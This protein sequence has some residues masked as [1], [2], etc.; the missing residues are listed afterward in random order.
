MLVRVDSFVRLS[1]FL[2]SICLASTGWSSGSTHTTNSNDS[3][4]PNILLIISDDQGYGD[5]GFNGNSVIETP[6][7][8]RLAQQSVRLTNFHVDPTCAETRAALMTG[9]YS[10]R[11]G[12]W[13]TVMGRNLL[14]TKS[15]TLPQALQDAGYKTG[16][17]GKWHLGDNSPY[18]PWQRGFGESL[19]HGGGGVGQ[20]PDHWGNDYFDDVYLHNG[21]PE[22]QNG[23][24][25][26][27]FA[28][29]AGQF[30]SDHKNEPF[31]CY[32]AFNAPHDP[33]NV[34]EDYRRKY[35]TKNVAEPMA[36]FYGMI[37]NI[38]EN[39]AKLMKLLDDEGLAENTI[40]VFMTD[41]GTAAGVNNNP[42]NDQWAG[43]NAG[44]RGTKGTVYEGGHRVP[45]FIRWPKGFKSD[46]EVNQLTAHFDLMPTLL[47]HC[48]VEPPAS[49]DPD[50]RD[51]SGLLTGSKKEW[52]ERTIVVHS[53]RVEHPEKSRKFVVMDD[54]WR[55]V[56]SELY[57]LYADPSQTTDVAKNNPEVVLRLTEQYDQFWER[58]SKDI[59]SYQYISL[60]EKAGEETLLTA[61]D[62][63]GPGPIAYQSQLEKD[64]IT[65][66]AWA[67]DVK[68]EG[69]YRFRLRRRPDGVEKPLGALR[70]EV[71]FGKFQMFKVIDPNVSEVQLEL[72][73]PVGTGMLETVLEPEDSSTDVTGAYYVYA[74]LG[75]RASE[76]PPPGPPQAADLGRKPG[77]NQKQ[78]FRNN[79][80]PPTATT[81]TIDF[82]SSNMP[83][84]SNSSGETE[85]TKSADSLFQSGERVAWLGATMVERMQWRDEL[86]TILA[87]RTAPLGVTF[88]NVG[89]S[90]DEATGRARAV[91]GGAEEGYQRR[92]KDLAAA[93]PTHVLVCYGINESFDVSLSGDVFRQ[94]MN[95][96]LDDLTK[97]GY[98][99]TLLLPPS[100]GAEQTEP[101]LQSYLQR[102]PMISSVLE[103]IA[104]ERKLKIYALPSIPANWTSNGIHL[105]A[106]GYSQYSRLVADLLVPSNCQLQ[107]D[108]ET[109]IVLDVSDEGSKKSIA[110]DEDGWVL[111]PQTS[112]GN[113]SWKWTEK[114]DCLPLPMAV[115]GEEIPVES[116][117]LYG[118]PVKVKGLSDG[119]YTLTINGQEVGR[120]D[121]K[122]WQEGVVCKA[123]G[124][125]QQV[126]K[127]RRWLH[128][129]NELFF[130]HYRPQNETYLFLFR[131]HEQGNNAV[132][133]D[134]FPPLIEPIE[135][136]IAQLSKPVEYQWSLEKV[137]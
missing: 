45:C 47:S 132:E 62:W 98:R 66:G 75:G 99:I 26:D 118:H 71:K 19:I 29:A 91:F 77:Q 58:A 37:T 97:A 84:S 127:L 6:A 109:A 76:P 68:K 83:E 32:L 116:D 25:S 120:G 18:R 48:K 5:I 79:E 67:I 61:M 108:R 126:E 101:R 23:Y 125:Q 86:E 28:R 69:N 21:R 38:D 119:L 20:V 72:R 8:D 90:G 136:E 135:K 35:L 82:C 52:E 78:E 134:Q 89:W 117:G 1:L 36:S 41:N 49:W 30:I 130:H 54:R 112:E 107:L 59:K 93:K 115:V 46:I 123:P 129:K 128:R 131:K 122:Q 70:A 73:L 105:N 4:R 12:V 11:G 7:L 2:I 102:R 111:Q 9:Q 33:Y 64:P 106:A 133:V 55:M 96:L 14:S 124:S 94:Q 34:A 137:K 60:G 85:Q 15:W 17:F 40:V 87:A 121:R 104:E 10:M 88:R 56:G 16:I 100:F 95:R 22:Q 92:I 27:V 50:G 3:T 74:S 39:I 103:S 43:F 57:D 53:Q 65:N 24:C 51:L 114:A 63:H 13:H 44:M 31:F 110:V 42:V 80:R 113:S 81:Q